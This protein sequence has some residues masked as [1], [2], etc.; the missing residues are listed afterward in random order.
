MKPTLLAAAAAALVLA[1]CTGP[2][3]VDTEGL[4]L[5]DFAARIGTDCEPADYLADEVTP[6][7]FQGLAETTFRADG[8]AINRSGVWVAADPYFEAAGAYELHG[9]TTPAEV[10]ALEVANQ[11]PAD[12]SEF[13]ASELT[14]DTT[15]GD[16]VEAEDLM[17]TMYLDGDVVALSQGA[18]VTQMTRSSPLQQWTTDVT[19]DGDEVT[20]SATITGADQSDAITVAWVFPG[21]VTDSNGDIQ[22]NAVVFTLGDTDRIYATAK[23]FDDEVLDT[24]RDPAA[25]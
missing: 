9:V 22:G 3:V 15:V 23:G 25:G 18:L 17:F 21:E 8:A 7:C 19:V 2:T 20:I 10:V 16:Y 5:P 4:D 14:E 1:A 24:L 11:D 6:E 13:L 12:Y